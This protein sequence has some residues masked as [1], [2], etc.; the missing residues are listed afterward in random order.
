M[1]NG[2]PLE[3]QYLKI[4]KLVKKLKSS[5]PST[6]FDRA[7][8]LISVVNLIEQKEVKMHELIKSI[9]MNKFIQ[10]GQYTLTNYGVWILTNSND[11]TFKLAC[12]G[13]R[14]NLEMILKKIQEPM[15]FLDIGANQG[16]FSL[17]AAKN[18]FFAEIHAFEPNP[19][20]CKILRINFLRN[21]TRGFK[22]HNYALSKHNSYSYL[23]VPIG[24]TGAGK[25]IKKKMTQ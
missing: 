19:H 8:K 16:I 23:S 3:I 14:N 12:M 17:V 7:L 13:Y 22:I 18:Q 10:A 11:K 9:F 5:L 1:I 24:H 20:L 25:I 6:L 4:M 21:K 15:L 2:T